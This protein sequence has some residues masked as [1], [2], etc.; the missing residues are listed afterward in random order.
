MRVSIFPYLNSLGHTVPALLIGEQLRERGAHVSFRGEGRYSSLVK[1]AAFRVREA[2]TFS[3][4]HNRRHELTLGQWTDDVVTKSIA[5][6]IAAIEDD[7]PDVIVGDFRPTLGISSRIARKP[8]VAISGAEL[9]RGF[10]Y[11][12]ALP[13]ILGFPRRLVDD[14]APAHIPALVEAFFYRAGRHLRRAADRFGVTLPGDG[15]LL[16]AWS[17]DLNLMPD[18]AELMPISNTLPNYHFI[19]PALCSLADPDE[20]LTRPSDN[21]HPLVYVSF[22]ST[23]M[24]PAGGTISTIVRAFADMPVRVVITSGGQFEMERDL[25][26]NVLVTEIADGM[27]L[28]RSAA[29][30]LCAG[31]KGTVYQ[32]LSQNTPVVCL[33]RN[34]DQWYIS[35]RVKRA[36]V[37]LFSIDPPTVRSLRA[38]LDEALSDR[39][40]RERARRMGE[41]IREL[42]AEQRAAPLIEAA[43]ARRS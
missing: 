36:G 32:S 6:E 3:E 23:G 16:D 13:R 33:P 18:V 37:G 30:T 24:A 2:F 7:R 34:H 43:A 40:M 17:G 27:S 21:G 15:S 9:T 4:E 25:P 35:E 22:G 19:G 42:S 38:M 5:E 41:R 8:F 29:V 26:S 11:P 1:R 31:G 28:A 20:R 10:A 39:S 14:T 12:L